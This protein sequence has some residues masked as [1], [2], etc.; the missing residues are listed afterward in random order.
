LTVTG[1]LRRTLVELGD[2]ARAL[3]LAADQI[4]TQPDSLI[5][6]KKGSK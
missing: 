2:A 5:F 3:G 6:G 4:Q 1:E